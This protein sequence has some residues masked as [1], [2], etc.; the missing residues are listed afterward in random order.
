MNKSETIIELLGEGGSI[1]L[2]GLQVNN[3]WFFTL[4]RNE[5]TLKESLDEDVSLYLSNSGY[6]K[7]FQAGIELLDQYPW[8]R[9]HPENINPHFAKDLYKE[10]TKRIS[11]RDRNR[12]STWK[13]A[14]EIAIKESEIKIERPNLFHFATSELSQDAFLC[15]LMSWAH[16]DYQTI[17]KKLHVVAVDFIKEIFTLHNKFA[18]TIE[19]IQIRQQ[20][21]G[22]D[23][24]V[25]INDEYAILIEDKTYTQD[26]SNQLIRYR[27]E[28]ETAYPNLIQLPIYYKITDQ[29]SYSSVKSAGYIPFNRRK[30]L[31]VLEDGIHNGVQDTIFIDYYNHLKKIENEV[32]SFWN[33]PIESWRALAWQGF[34]LELQKELP[35]D[36]DYVS[37][38]SGGFWGFW[39]D[40]SKEHY[41]YLQLEQTKLCIKID[42]TNAE[43]KAKV[44]NEAMEK[45]LSESKEQ[46]LFLQRP[47]R[48]GNGRTMTIAQRM[49]YIQTTED[50]LIDME[51]TIAELK[52]Y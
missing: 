26:H 14:L 10:V 25:I 24:L 37:N 19:S 5:L 49:D 36:W 52:K 48:L 50:G 21:K 45:V 18:P 16:Q 39:W 15:W 11:E 42:A 38:A 30:A 51:K 1:T 13:K 29:G 23:I 32:T 9:L 34:Y 47:A 12:L 7:G 44:R 4:N 22:L 35:G 6:V 33:T 27:A 46:D 2:H 28:I 8:T 40:S 3:E 31:K 41:Y 20:F 43:N 17:D